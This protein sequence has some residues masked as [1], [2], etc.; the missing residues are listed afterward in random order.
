M[1]SK[2]VFAFAVIIF[3]MAALACSTVSAPKSPDVVTTV[4]AAATEVKSAIAG[5]ATPTAK[6]GTAATPIPSSGGA[7]ENPLSLNDRQAGLDKLKSYRTKWQMD[8]KSTEGASTQ[9][10]SWLWTEEYSSDPKALHWTMSLTDSQDKSKNQSME[11]WQIGDTTYMLTKD[12]SGK[13]E[14]MSFSSSDQA[15]QLQQGLFNPSSLGGV[16]DAKFVSAETVNGIKTRHYK[17]DE[18][19]IT[20]AGAA[21]VA[22]E[23]WVA[24]DGGYVVKEVMTWSGA[25]GLFGAGST[26]GD[27]KWLWELTDVDQAITIKAPENCGG[28][29]S[30]F[31]IMKDATDKSS[32]GDMLTYKTPSKVVDV[33]KFYQTQMP[34]A[35]WKAQG[36]A[37][38]TDQFAQMQF[39]KDGKT[40]QVMISVESGKTNVTVVVG[41]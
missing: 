40:A 24:V 37:T 23:M 19:S 41:K 13:G 1:K 29:A 11:W 2:S 7:D 14:C 30:D 6:P 22:G 10:S 4:Q 26:K 28:A 31:P 16:K 12:A 18:K 32:F 35:G 8:W 27:G 15:S 33:V 25:A 21:K 3:A 17:Y 20:L 9:T 5:T 36:D 39:A 38:I 34:A